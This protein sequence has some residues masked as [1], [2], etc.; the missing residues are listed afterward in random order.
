MI[1]DT[2]QNIDH[3]DEPQRKLWKLI[4]QQSAVYLL[5]GLVGIVLLANEIQKQLEGEI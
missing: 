1:Y 4:P 3:G 2:I 5:S